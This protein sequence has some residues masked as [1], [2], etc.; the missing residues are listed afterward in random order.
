MLAMEYWHFEEDQ[1]EEVPKYVDCF[2]AGEPQ[3]LEIK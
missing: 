1:Q 3:V 2:T